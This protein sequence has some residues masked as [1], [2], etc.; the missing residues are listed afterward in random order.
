MPRSVKSRAGPKF[1]VT[2]FGWLLQED[3]IPGDPAM[4][5]G[6]GTCWIPPQNGSQWAVYRGKPQSYKA[7]T[8]EGFESHF[9]F[10]IS[11]IGQGLWHGFTTLSFKMGLDE[12]LG[13]SKYWVCPIIF[14]YDIPIKTLA[15]WAVFT[16]PVGWWCVRGFSNILGN[17]TWGLRPGWKRLHVSRLPS[18]MKPQWV[19]SCSWRRRHGAVRS[20][21]GSCVATGCEAYHLWTS[22][23]FW[24]WFLD[25]IPQWS[26]WSTMFRPLL[27]FATQE[28]VSLSTSMPKHVNKAVQPNK[29]SGC[30]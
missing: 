16:T 12:S 24:T 2:F 6:R 26:P 9:F 1:Q 17:I 14:S 11:C 29:N 18:S 23:S 28:P 13:W 30:F 15:M 8:L 20:S 22:G 3:E 25:L 4:V 21:E 10:D 27:V 19:S 7:Q 5:W